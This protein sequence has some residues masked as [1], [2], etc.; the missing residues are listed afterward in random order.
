[1]CIDKIA[2][3]SRRIATQLLQCMPWA[4]HIASEPR[5]RLASSPGAREVTWRGPHGSLPARR[6]LTWATQPSGY[7]ADPSHLHHCHG[8]AARTHRVGGE[9]DTATD[10]HSREEFV[11]CWSSH[12]QPCVASSHGCHMLGPWWPGWSSTVLAC[13]C[14]WYLI[15]CS[16]QWHQGYVWR[17]ASKLSTAVL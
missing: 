11:V 7:Q 15:V 14:G 6:P 9:E 16:S 4:G 8:I 3:H 17:E 13:V 12:G 10:D 2:Q 1:M 5:F